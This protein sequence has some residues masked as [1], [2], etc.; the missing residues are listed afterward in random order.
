MIRRIISRMAE[1]H[2]ARKFLLYVAE[3]YKTNSAKGIRVDYSHTKNLE[4]DY[5]KRIV[6]D[7]DLLVEEQG[8]VS[9]KVSKGLYEQ[10]RTSVYRLTKRGYRLIKKFGAFWLWVEDND[11]RLNIIIGLIGGFLLGLVSV[12]IA[13]IAL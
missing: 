6:S 9:V 2:D 13:I 4:I 8:E 12:A 3:N 5:L 10:R 11:K 1:Y 7:L